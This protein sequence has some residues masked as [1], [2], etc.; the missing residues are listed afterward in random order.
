MSGE[1]VHDLSDRQ[2]LASLAECLQVAEARLRV[3]KVELYGTGPRALVEIHLSDGQVLTCDR[4]G[5]LM[6]AAKLNALVT[7]TIGHATAIKGPGAAQACALIRRLAEVH[8]AQTERDITLDWVSDFL[9]HADERVVNFG[10]QADRFRAF[11][12]VDA[13][14]PV[15]NALR[16]GASV[17]SDSVVLRDEN[18]RRYVHCGWILAH[19]RRAWQPIAAR[20]LTDRLE[21]IGWTRPGKRGRMMARAVGRPVSIVLP[22]WWV[23]PGWEV[24]TGEDD[25]SPGA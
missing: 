19:V 20:E 5:D 4:F 8:E 2:M 14:D 9:S 21:H 7:T 10:D 11:A 1:N 25:D 3:T 15:R 6:Q 18:C 24:P 16:T 23:P 12:A 13:Q 17:A 22:F